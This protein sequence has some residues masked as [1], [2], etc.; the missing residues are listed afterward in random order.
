MIKNQIRNV[1]SSNCLRFAPE[2]LLL[3]AAT[4]IRLMVLPSIPFMH[5][6]FSA[7][8]RTGYD[9]WSEL[10]QQGVVPDAHP[11]GTQLLIAF[12]TNFFGWNSFWIKLPFTLLGIVSVWLVYLTGKQLFN[13]TAGLFAA[14]MV[15][16]M[17]YFVFYSQLARPYSTGLFFVLL[18]AY[19]GIRIVENVV[20]HRRLYGVVFVTALVSAAM[21]HYFAMMMAGFVYLG[22]FAMAHREQRRSIFFY[23]IAAVILWFPNISLAIS[24]LTAGGIGDW[25]AKPE[26][27]FIFGFLKYTFHFSWVFSLVVTGIF[28]AA[29]TYRMPAGRDL[30]WLMLFVSWFV[31]SFAIG[32]IYS[33]VRT[34]VLQFSTLYFSFPFLLLGISGFIKPLSE[35]RNLLLTAALLLAGVYSLTVERQHF[36]LM[37][38]QGYE[39]IAAGFEEAIATTG[40]NL[41]CAA[42]GGSARMLDFYQQRH[43]N[44]GVRL[45]NKD[46]EKQNFE[47]FLD[48]IT[49][50]F[51]TVGWSDYT[52]YSWIEAA[53]ARFPYIVK[54]TNWFNSGY[55]LLSKDSSAAS[56]SCLNERTVLMESDDQGIKRFAGA[57]EY[58]MLWE[59]DY[60]SVRKQTDGILVAGIELLPAMPAE[61]VSLVLEIKTKGQATP[62]LWRSGTSEGRILNENQKAWLVVAYHLDSGPAI[63]AGSTLRL[64]VWNKKKESFVVKKRWLRIIDYDPVLFGFYAPL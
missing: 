57:D 13:K 63:P 8:F 30:K 9:S 16:V 20:K 54:K 55:Y 25:L 10:I 47:F 31:L 62:Y 36:R 40:N 53:R 50:R 56:L 64:Y 60:D 28:L 15:A 52:T 23:G 42:V 18:A 3:L 27:D 48:S 35:T 45:F 33:V 2:V 24:Q 1:F 61:G 12:I 34:P 29:L 14:S 49:T 17:Q 19:S 21:M 58:G 7:L 59:A 11:A 43:G 44:Q 22:L 6:E 51:L 41:S 4:T 38:Q 37:T 26:S 5:D 39:Q 46:K 32:W